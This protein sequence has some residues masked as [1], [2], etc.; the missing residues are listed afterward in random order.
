MDPDCEGTECLLERALPGLGL[1]VLRSRPVFCQRRAGLSGISFGKSHPVALHSISTRRNNIV[2]QLPIIVTYLSAIFAS[3]DDPQPNAFTRALDRQ[4][5]NSMIPCRSQSE[6]C[7]N[8]P[9]Q[10]AQIRCSRF[11]RLTQTDT[12]SWTSLMCLRAQSED[13]SMR[14][15]A[16]GQLISVVAASQLQ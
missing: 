11:W 1:E 9:V 12:V 16:P 7:G 6:T 8:A 3:P 4:G 5:K 10:I 2:H 14:A 13:H 15:A